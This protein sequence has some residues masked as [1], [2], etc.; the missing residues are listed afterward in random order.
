MEN[1]HVTIERV[2]AYRPS[3]AKKTDHSKSVHKLFVELVR[4]LE[5]LTDS[6][7]PKPSS[8][9]L[10]RWE[11]EDNI[12]LET[13]VSSVFAREIDVNVHN[14]KVYIRLAR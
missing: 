8:G 13:D 2:H 6:P 9:S 3:A 10:D 1:V 7:L 11:D 14:G 12:Y 5:R 4:I